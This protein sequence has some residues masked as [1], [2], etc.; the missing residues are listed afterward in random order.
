MTDRPVFIS[1]EKVRREMEAAL[2]SETDA[3]NQHWSPEAK[4]LRDTL[5]KQGATLGLSPEQQREVAMRWA[6]KQIERARNEGRLLSPQQAK[7]QEAKRKFAVG[8]KARYIGPDRDEQL[9]GE[10]ATA[11]R[12]SGQLGKITRV[13]KDA[14]PGRIVTFRPFPKEG[15]TRIVELQVR[16]GTPGFLTIERVPE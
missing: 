10:S 12:P 7:D 16:E 3:R 9:A 13:H 4:E 11:R 6:E 1:E 2:T 8:D 14:L 5:V 15:A